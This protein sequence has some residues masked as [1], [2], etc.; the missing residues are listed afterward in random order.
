MSHGTEFL[1]DKKRPRRG[2]KFI[3]HPL[4]GQFTILLLGPEG[5]GIIPLSQPKAIAL[6]SSILSAVIIKNGIPPM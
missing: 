4:R 5:I 6:D 1:L 2:V 3:E